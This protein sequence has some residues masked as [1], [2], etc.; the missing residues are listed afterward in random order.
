MSG[1]PSHPGDFV[2]HTYDDTAPPNVTEPQL[3]HRGATAA[4][5][6]ERPR[7]EHGL[8]ALLAEQR[9][10]GKALPRLQPIGVY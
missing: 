6:A 3:D 10:Q 7:A 4:A 5:A 2:H 1:V 8:Q 9:V